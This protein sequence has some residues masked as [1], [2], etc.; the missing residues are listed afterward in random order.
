MAAASRGYSEQAVTSIRMPVRYQPHVGMPSLGWAVLAYC[1][2]LSLVVGG[3]GQVFSVFVL[4]LERDIGLLRADVASIYSAI[5]LTSGL[6]G[7]FAG[8]LFER[9][10]P[11]RL[12]TAGLLFLA[13]GYF[14]G[15]RAEMLW[16]LQLGI[17]LLVGA[18]SALAGGVPHAALVARWFETRVGT[19]MGII[20]S[21]GG[22]ASFFVAPLT[23]IAIDN[24]G[25]R[26]AYTLFAAAL[27]AL[28]PVAVVYPWRRIMK[29]SAGWR[30]ERRRAAKP[31]SGAV[32]WTLGS[33][34][35]TQTFW[36]MFFVYFFTGG[37]T[38]TLAVHMVSYLVGRGID[39]LTAA[40]AFGFAGFLTPLGMIGFG[41]LGDSIGKARAAALSYTLTG[42]S[43]AGLFA[44][45]FLPSLWVVLPTM[46]CFGVSS[47][48]RGPLISAIA[49]NVFAGQRAGGI[50]GGITLGGGLGSAFGAWFGG[51]LQDLTGTSEA[52]IAFTAVFLVLGSAPF[53]AVRNLRRT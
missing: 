25:W 28:I 30:R 19:A 37:A 12:Y 49:M 15:S 11:R 14:V 32:V 46:I 43:V 20:F 18:G 45:S 29:G 34:M 40:A 38:V 24:W 13:V 39:P 48:S 53:W 4:P 23:Q 10:G 7:P 35:R 8:A 21:A 9:F 50:Y 1:T 31:D 41:F 22:F 3:M 44:L 27:A 17:G 33:A 52:L 51:Y 6:L 5:M 47:G 2:G 16:Q 42:L 26:A 36:G